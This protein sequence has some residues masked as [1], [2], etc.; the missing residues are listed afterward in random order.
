MPEPITLSFS[1]DPENLVVVRQVGAATAAR[2]GLSIDRADDARLAVDEATTLLIEGGATSIVCAFEVAPGRL[3]IQVTGQGGRLPS[4][5]EL[6]WTVLHAL[7]N[8]LT[9]L[10]AGSDNRITI[11]IREEQPSLT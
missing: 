9:T 11:A 1:A 7:V 6:S 8:D 4:P 2:C 10:E 5:E 3:E